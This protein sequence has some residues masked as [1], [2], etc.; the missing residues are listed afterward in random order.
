MWQSMRP[1]GIIFARRG[2]FNPLVRGAGLVGPGHIGQVPFEATL[3]LGHIAAP[4][5]G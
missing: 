1:G 3:G 5:A 2:R 4:V